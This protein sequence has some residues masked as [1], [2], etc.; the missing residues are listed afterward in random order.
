MYHNVRTSPLPSGVS[1]V[2]HCG[3]YISKLELTNNSKNFKPEGFK[4]LLFQ[5]GCFAFR[6]DFSVISVWLHRLCVDLYTAARNSSVFPICMQ[7]PVTSTDRRGGKSTQVWGMPFLTI[8]EV[9]LCAR[10]HGQSDK[11]HC[12][13]CRNSYEVSGVSLRRGSYLFL[14]LATVFWPH[15]RAS[16]WR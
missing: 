9:R 3:T 4:I 14:N 5:T 2:E 10:L 8:S 7:A 16:Q 11:Y 12:L 6:M 1:C 15:R 13:E